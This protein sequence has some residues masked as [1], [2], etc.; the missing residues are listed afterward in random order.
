M[1]NHNRKQACQAKLSEI[2]TTAETWVSVLTL[3]ASSENGTR[4]DHQVEI[5][6]PDVH[7]LTMEFLDT[8][9]CIKR[10]GKSGSVSIVSCFFLCPFPH[11]A[12]HSDAA[13]DRAFTAWSS[14]GSG[15]GAMRPTIPRYHTASHCSTPCSI[16][17]HLV[18]SL[19]QHK[20]EQN[21]AY[22]YGIFLYSLCTFKIKP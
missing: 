5:H 16:S 6:L 18:P 21:Q 20:S 2:A 19:P 13:S 4:W 9:P 12:W 22:P 8:E 14:L 15:R 10:F 3:S 17:F 11:L 1:W 7:K